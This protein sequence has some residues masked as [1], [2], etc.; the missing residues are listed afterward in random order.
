[1][2]FWA[3]DMNVT[4]KDG[5]FLDQPG[6]PIMYSL[7]QYVSYFYTIHQLYQLGRDSLTDRV[8]PYLKKRFSDHYQLGEPTF[9]CRGVRSDF[10]FLSHFSMKFLQANRKALDGTPR[11]AASHL[12]LCCLPMS[13]KRDVRLK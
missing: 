10:E 13:H 5:S 8:N 4:C 2:I 12:G 6:Y 7:T 9:I 1:M 3:N 11:A